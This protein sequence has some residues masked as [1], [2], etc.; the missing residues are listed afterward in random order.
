MRRELRERFPCHRGL[1]IPTEPRHVRDARAV[2]HD[3]IAN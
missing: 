1:A 2:M 3:G